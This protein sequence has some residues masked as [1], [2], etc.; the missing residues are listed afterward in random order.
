[1]VGMPFIWN[2]TQLFYHNYLTYFKL[3]ALYFA[4]FLVF[5]VAFKYLKKLQA[6]RSFKLVRWGLFCGMIMIPISK[7]IVNIIFAF[8]FAM[9]VQRIDEVS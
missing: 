5:Y 1:M 2:L 3:V 9:L 4:F 7:S 8:I 6:I